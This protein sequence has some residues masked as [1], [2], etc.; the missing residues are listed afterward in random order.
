MTVY[1]AYNEVEEAVV[2]GRRDR[3]AAAPRRAFPAGRLCRDVP[4]QRPEPRAGRSVCAARDEVPAGGRHA[5]L[6]AQG[7][8]GRPGLSAPDP[9]PGRQRGAGPHHQRAAARHR[10]QDAG[11]AALVGGR[12]RREPVR[13]AAG[14][15]S[16]ARAR[17]QR[18]LGGALPPP[19]PTRPPLG[20]RAQK[21]LADF[22]ALLEG[23]VDHG[24]QRPLRQRGRAA[25]QRAGQ[26]GLCTHAARRHRRGRGS[27]CQPAGTAQ[28]GGTICA[29]HARPG[30]R[31]D[32]SGPIPGGDQPG[33][34]QRRPGS[35]EGAGGGHAADAAH[36]QGAGVSR[37]LHRRPGRGHP[38]AQ[39]QP[40][41]RRP[42]RD[43]R[44]APPVL[45]RHHARQAAA[46]PGALLPAQPVGRQQRAG[47]QPLPGRDSRRP[48]H[49][50]GGQAQPPGEQLQA[51]D[52]VGRRGRGQPHPAQPDRRP[53]ERALQVGAAA[54]G[55]G[56]QRHLRPAAVEGRRGKGNY[57]SPG[58]QR[59]QGAHSRRASP[60]RRKST[61][62]Q[63]AARRPVPAPRQRA[64]CLLWRRHRHRKQHHA[65]RRKK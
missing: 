9:Q 3:E 35:I 47:P 31:P 36:G 51:H 38:A 42:R 23:W 60:L 62:A 12:D 17:R 44:G 24:A 22:S 21:A 15:P 48:A 34:R 27:L 63:P 13:G 45:C 28:R 56:Q 11:R 20:G 65:R 18:R 54:V 14:A 26:V 5:L 55:P 41:E 53:V 6:R 57:W 29:G 19:R 52:R 10:R 25:R 46:L 2:C 32:A 7:D 30:D 50:H 8:Q 43:G 16:R 39:P 33:Q 58:G 59:S 1:E 40:G 37:R 64:A 4:H 61:A 49:G